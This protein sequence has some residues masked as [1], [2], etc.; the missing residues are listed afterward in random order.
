M[1]CILFTLPDGSRRE[2]DAEI[3][4]TLKDLALR[5]SLPGIAGECGGVCACAT[6]HVL[7][8]PEWSNIVG[9][10]PDFEEEMLTIA[11]N[12]GKYS[13]LGCQVEVTTEL[14]GLELSIPGAA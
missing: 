8:S 14:N 9:E 5:H 1:I 7:I 11:D 2:V 6:C 12:R 4:E 10:P 3:G 13:R